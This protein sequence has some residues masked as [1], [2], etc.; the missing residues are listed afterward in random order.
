MARIVE[1]ALGDVIVEALS[2]RGFT[3]ALMAAAGLH[4]ALGAAFLEWQARRAR[5]ADELTATRIDVR[6]GPP[7]GR[8]EPPP[9]PAVA[10]AA[11]PVAQPSRTE[12]AAMS[13]PITPT[14][15]PPPAPPC[16][17]LSSGLGEGEGG[18]A[19]PEPTVEAPPAAAPPPIDPAV[20]KAY[21]NR[22]VGYIYERLVYPRRRCA[23]RW[24]AGRCWCSR[25]TGAGAL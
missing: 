12:R 18:L 7:G 8:L 16:A 1:S 2:P 11:E 14:A 17:R 13:P 15:P 22:A 5:P 4:L 3:L 6:L 10:P 21:A 23:T 19:P 20:L 9:P 24:R 25:S